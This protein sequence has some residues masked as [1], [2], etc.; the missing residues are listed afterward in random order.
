MEISKGAERKAKEYLSKYREAREAYES[1][2]VALE[3]VETQINHITIDY[4]KTRVK[5][6]TKPDKYGDVIDRLII[7]RREFVNAADKHSKAMEEVYRTINNAR[8][9][10]NRNILTRYYIAGQTFDEIASDLAY[11]WQGIYKCY[12]RALYDYIR[13]NPE[14]I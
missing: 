11:S 14:I 4:E 10:Q 7:M 3:E 2:R 13:N 6:T 12:K 5:S 9:A 1:A 8:S